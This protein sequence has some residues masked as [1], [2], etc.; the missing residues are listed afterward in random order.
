MSIEEILAEMENLVLD[1]SRLPLTN[2]RVI[3]EVD[4]AD[5]ID[6]LRKALPK[7]ISEAKRIVGE[8]QQIMECAQKEAQNIVAQAQSY[9]CK[10][11]DEN[12]ISWQAHEKANEVMLKSQAAAQDLHNHA[13][14][15]AGD[16]FKYVEDVLDKTL[17]IIRQEQ[18]NIAN[19]QN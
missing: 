6:N 14:N 10:L 9:V 1:A 11:T 7:E 3:D 18:Q 19:R 16:V 15:Y 13:L 5:L 4:L 17:N 8:C 12:I 2:K